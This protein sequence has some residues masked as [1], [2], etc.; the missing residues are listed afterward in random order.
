VLSVS[1]LVLTAGM[2]TWLHTC[3]WQ[4]AVLGC[5]FQRCCCCLLQPHFSAGTVK[6]SSH[7]SNAQNVQCL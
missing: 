1:L 6:T 2:L 7:N 4:W 3:M 5:A